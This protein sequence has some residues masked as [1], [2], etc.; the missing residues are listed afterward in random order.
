MFGHWYLVTNQKTA[1]VFTE[2]TSR[3]RLVLLKQLENPLA[4][5]RNRDMV[6]RQAGMGIRSAGVGGTPYSE[7]QRS[8]PHE[9]AAY[10]FAKEIM[11]FLDSEKRQK[12]FETITIIAEPRFL[13]KLRSAMS[14]NLS[15][16]VLEWVQKDLL[17]E[18]LKRLTQDLLSLKRVSPELSHQII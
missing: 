18:P 1:K 3:G 13:G 9:E 11:K 14:K 15:R 8:D 2:T 6:R 10:Q 12:N 17:K 4:N 7:K 16:V 5:V